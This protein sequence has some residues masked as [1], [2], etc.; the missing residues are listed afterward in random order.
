[1]KKKLFV[2]FLITVLILSTCIINGHA[3]QVDSLAQ[4]AATSRI[5]P[6]GSSDLHANSELSAVKADALPSKYSSKD[7]GYTTEVRQQSANICWAYSSLA[8]LETLLLKSGERVGHFSPEHMNVWGSKE[9]SGNGWQRTDLINDGGYSYISMGYLTSWNGPLNDNEFPV[10]TDK[11]EFETV[12]S[13]YS[14]GYGVTGIKYITQST[15]LDTVKSYVMDYGAVIANYNADTVNYMNSSSD[16]FYCSDP[17]ISTAQL[18][19]HAVSIVGWDDNYAK[20]NFSTSFSGDTPAEDGAWL[21]KNS[22]GKYVNT[23][24]GYFWISYEDAWLFHSIFGPS[25]A[26]S[27]YEKLDGSQKL[28]QNEIYGATTEFCYLTNEDD[29]PA[30]EI[31]YMNVFDFSG[32]HDTLDKVTFESTSFGADYTIYYIP[33]YGGKP[34]QETFLWQKLGEGTV[35]YTGYITADVTDYTLPEGKGA[36]GVAIDNTRTYT[37]NKDKADYEYIPNGIGVSEW[38]AY[39]GGY[40][41]KHQGNSGESFVMYNEYSLTKFYDLMDFYSEYLNDDMGAT[42]VIKAITKDTDFI[43]TDNTEPSTVEVTTTE[44]SPTVI[45]P[46]TLGITLEFVGDTRLNVVANASG[47]T[48]GYQYEFIVNNTVVSDY[49]ETSYKSLNFTGDGNYV[50]EISVK[51]SSGRVV[52]TQ[53]TATVENGKLVTPGASRPSDPVDTTDPSEQPT[54]PTETYT[55]AT[56]TTVPAQNGKA[57]IMGDCDTNGKLNVKDAT[58]IQK[59]LAKL[60]DFDETAQTLADVDGNGKCTIKDATCVQKHLAKIKT[61]STTGQTVMIYYK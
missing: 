12:N 47:G 59:F 20:E 35:D 13:L 39:S 55:E 45:N 57:F 6:I 1:M 50:I 32:E 41:F 5:E 31:T 42:F 2:F 54:V 14:P 9:A 8:S 38:L 33:V 53:T 21:I 22:W 58:G 30:D 27:D 36:I 61:D 11:S 3:R 56:T 60:V 10:G 23:S 34:T 48:G 52:S 29:I 49:S 25:F 4:I 26:I 44:S 16:A 43:P 7:L 17:S 18:N 28:Y 24:G 51:D 40:Y 15:P 46:I 19:G 37:A